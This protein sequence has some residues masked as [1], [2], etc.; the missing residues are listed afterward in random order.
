MTR[1]SRFLFASLCVALMTIAPLTAQQSNAEGSI[2]IPH[3]IRFTGVLKDADGKPAQRTEGVTFAFYKDERGGAPLWMETQNVTPDASGRYSVMLG[4]T[5]SEGLPA[6]L[7]ISKEARWLGVEPQ[8]LPVPV[9]VLLL[10]V[11]YAL[12]AADAETIGGLPPSAFVLA[13][14][15]SS[16]LPSNAGSSTSSPSVP[17][18]VTTSGGTVNLIPLWS[19]ATDIESSAISQTGSGA[20]AKIGIGT[21]AP[22]TTLDVKGSATIRGAASVLGALSLPATGTATATAG[23]SSQPAN[24]AAS[25]FNGSNSTAVTQTFQFKAEPVGNNTAT[26]SATLNLLFGTGTAAPTETGLKI[27]NHGVFTF[28]PSQTFPGTGNGTITG[29]TAGSG[30]TG[31]GNSG[32]VT[33][34]VDTSK[35]VTGIAA[36]S[37]LTGGG[38]GGIQA[39]S[40]DTSKVPLLS[41]SNTFTGNQ[42]VVGN[43]SSN[44]QVSGSVV[45]A[46]TSFNLAGNP[47]AFGS[48]NTA[49]AFLGFAGNQTMTGGDNVATGQVALL[50]NTTGGSNSADG[51]GTLKANTTGSNNSALGFFALSNN[52]TGSN[53]TALGANAGPDSSHPALTNATAIGAN[54]QVTVSN[55]LVLGSINGVNGATA[56]TVVGIGTTAPTAKLD[57]RGTAN[58]GGLVSFAAGQTFPGTG[59]ITGVTAGSG[60]TGG[61]SSG[62]VTLS[63]N[64]SYTDGRYAQLAANNTF[65]GVQVMNNSVGIGVSSPAYPLHVAGAIRSETGGLSLGGNATLGV[66]APGIIGGRL[67]IL[68]NGNVGINN[69]NPTTTLDVNGNIDARGTLI[70][71]SLNVSGGGVINGGLITSA[72]I[73]TGAGV[74]VGAGLTVT[75]NTTVGGSLKIQNDP[76]MNAAPR[77][78]LTGFIPGP[79]DAFTV[80]APIT[81]LFSKAVLITRVTGTG[82]NP[83]PGSGPLDFAILTRPTNTTNWVDV[84]DLVLTGNAGDALTDSLPLSIPIAAG[85]VVAGAL[86]PPECPPGS[87]E[88][89]DLAFSIEYIMQ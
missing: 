47:F 33:L 86:Y 1:S 64:N 14:P 79:V 57:V 58:F 36:G 76:P 39:L 35:V 19:T 4:A 50:N 81:T 7:F 26:P 10:S 75:G 52:L 80:F 23:K 56:D 24:L 45:N 82:T 38:N 69:P 54:A 63:L 88:P 46:L 85:T 43:L 31:G 20:T 72:G 71:G 16:A 89:V 73:T 62:G 74:S 87:G 84:Y 70:G 55:A 68:A 44:G 9:R 49:N 67:A 53:N 25:S 77:M 6:E 65:S 8:G 11:P 83:C 51:V 5:K 2:S 17:S 66:D 28:A 12:K 34:S 59:T 40:L 78:Y 13:A 41:A 18:D 42:A 32:G 37:G 60:L 22:A 29:V 61:G 30:L 3:L 21:T 15:S 27:N 48:M